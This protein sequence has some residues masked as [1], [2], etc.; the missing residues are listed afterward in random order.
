[1]EES[2]GVAQ[3]RA[4]V[5]MEDDEHGYLLHR[6]NVKALFLLRRLS[7]RRGPAG[8]SLGDAAPLR[9]HCTV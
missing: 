6:I 2:T 9:S 4:L 3:K 7:L 8:S 5:V 1:M